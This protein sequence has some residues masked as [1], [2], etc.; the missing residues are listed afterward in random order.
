MSI[1]VPPTLVPLIGRISPCHIVPLPAV[2]PALGVGV[3][4]GV[5]VAAPPAGTGVADGSGLPP[6]DEAHA[7][8]SAAPERARRVRIRME[9]T[10]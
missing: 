1:A 2:C 9:V 6:D 4:V 3:G 8:E 5:A 10:W 7:A